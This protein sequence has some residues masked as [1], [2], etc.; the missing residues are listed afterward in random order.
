MAE[1]KFVLGLLVLAAWTAQG[2]TPSDA[3]RLAFTQRPGAMLPASQPFRDANGSLVSVPQLAGGRPMLLLLGYFQCPNLCPV[4]RASLYRALS[5]AKLQAGR[6]Y[7][8]AV[9]SI[10]PHE[11]VESAQSA[12]NKDLADFSPLGSM[13]AI[14]YLTGDEAAVNALSSAVGFHDRWDG[15]AREFLHPAGLIFATK[16]G[17]VSSYLL[18][19]GYRPDQLRDGLRRAANR[20]APPIYAEPILLLCFHYDP[21]TGRYSFEILKLLRLAGIASVLLI[22]AALFFLFRRERRLV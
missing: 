14:H 9:V 11:S 5:A 21:S 4:T 2:A 12:L 6:D 15:A 10:D 16:D 20:F 13:S 22:A 18:G 8:L 1:M 19:V 7:S 17:K 3:E